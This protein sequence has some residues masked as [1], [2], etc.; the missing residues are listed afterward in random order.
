LFC[1]PKRVFQTLGYWNEE[2]GSFGVEDGDYTLRVDLSD[3]IRGFFPDF[4][5]GEHIG[6]SDGNIEGYVDFKKARQHDQ[7]SP[8]GLFMVN[9]LLYDL[10]LK[11]FY[12]DKRYI[13]Q[14][15]D[16][17][18]IHKIDT[19]K[20]AIN[21]KWQEAARK[22]IENDKTEHSSKQEAREII[23]KYYNEL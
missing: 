12:V 8:T 9:E 20:E 18:I 2:Y 22:F 15:T 19:E 16:G 21:L 13:T 23:I 5:W 4:T 17:L 1:I 11:S 7:T 3:M 10:G 6:T 14:M